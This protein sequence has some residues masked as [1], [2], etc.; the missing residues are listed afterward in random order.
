MRSKDVLKNKFLF[1]DNCD[2]SFFD[3]G[4]N[5]DEDIIKMAYDNA[6]IS[7]ENKFLSLSNA[8]LC[9]APTAIFFIITSG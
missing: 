8:R 3:K 7:L 4:Y 9:F 6:K 5:Y 1:I 2:K